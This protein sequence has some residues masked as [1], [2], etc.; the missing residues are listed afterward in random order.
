MPEPYVGMEFGSFKS[1]VEKMKSKTG[2]YNINSNFDNSIKRQVIA[3]SFWNDDVELIASGECNLNRNKIN[4]DEYL[5]GNASFWEDVDGQKIRYTG[6]TYDPENDD[7]IFDKI[8]G[9]KTYAI[10]RNEDGEVG[11]GEIFDKAT[12]KCI[13]P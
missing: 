4:S 2:T 6:K 11:P 13:N 5:G 9:E 3:T 10:D 1:M 7:V 12:K 8:V